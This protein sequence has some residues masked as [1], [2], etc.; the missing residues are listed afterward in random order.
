MRAFS[1]DKSLGSRFHNLGIDWLVDGIS[2]GSFVAQRTRHRQADTPISPTSGATAYARS[3][4][5]I[6]RRSYDL[7][8][9]SARYRRSTF[10]T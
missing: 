4:I 7:R 3:A 10:S 1:L 5:C 6:A 8:L 2:S 9:S